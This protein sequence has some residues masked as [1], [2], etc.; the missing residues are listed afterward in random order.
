MYTYIE[1]MIGDVRRRGH[2][3]DPLAEAWRGQGTKVTICMY[4]NL[5]TYHQ[6][7]DADPLVVG[8]VLQRRH[9]LNRLAKTWRRQGTV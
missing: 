7:G 9:G 6:E 4:I 5:Y 2:G 1:N 3:L 8:N